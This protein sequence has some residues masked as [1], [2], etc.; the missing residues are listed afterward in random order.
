MSDS[1]ISKIE[2]RACRGGDEL[3]DLNAVETIHLPG[4]SRPDLTFVSITTTDRVTGTS[5]GFGSLDAK[6]DAET[7]HL[8]IHMHH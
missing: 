5:F 2:I 4:G 7:T 3:N 6:A 1:M 8:S